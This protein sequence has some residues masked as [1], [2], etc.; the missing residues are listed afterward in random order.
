MLAPA[1]ARAGPTLRSRRALHLGEAT[2][3]DARQPASCAKLGPA[4]TGCRRSCWRYETGARLDRGIPARRADIRPRALRQ[5]GGHGFRRATECRACPPRSPLIMFGLGL[6]ADRWADLGAFGRPVPPKAVGIAPWSC[7]C[8][9][10]R[11]SASGW[12]SPSICRPAARGRPDAAGRLP[13]R[14]DGE[15]VQPPVPRRRG[16]QHH[17]HG[18]QLADRRVTLPLITN[19][20]IAYFDPAGA[21]SLGLQFGKTVQV[22]AIVLVPVALGM[23]VRAR[24]PAFADRMDRPVRIASAVVLAAGDPRHDRWPS[25]R[26]SPATSPRSG[27]PPCSSACSA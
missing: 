17:A 4:A 24:A 5:D 22:F 2:G 25:A 8:S 10:C 1:R 16:A 27:C 15:P 12:C 13:R 3:Q 18:G 14:H 11:R 7:S 26:T 23:L 20:A 21:G 6:S 19:L 9:C